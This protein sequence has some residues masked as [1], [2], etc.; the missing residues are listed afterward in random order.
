MSALSPDK[1]LRYYNFES[2]SFTLPE[3]G[4]LSIAIMVAM[5]TGG[6]DLSVVGIA[7][8]AAVLAGTL[9]HHLAP[10]ASASLGLGSVSLGVVLA[11]GHRARRGSAERLSHRPAAHHPH[12]GDARHQPD[13][14]GPRSGSDR[15]PR[16]RGVSGRLELYRQRQGAGRRLSRSSSSSSSPPPSASSCP[17]PPSA[18]GSCSSA[19][20]PRRRSSRGSGRNASCSRA[21]SSPASSPASRG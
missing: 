4:L 11:L 20:T 13:L 1:F 3:L 15:R 21:T 2:I 12:P 5:L 7:N 10:G 9:F 16:H 18:R 8:L 17:G 14:H 19:P 6:I